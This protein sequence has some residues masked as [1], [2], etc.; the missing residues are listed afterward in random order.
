MDSETYNTLLKLELVNVK[1]VKLKVIETDALRMVKKER[2]LNEYCWTLKPFFLEYVLL[3]YGDLDRVTHLDADLYFYSDPTRLFEN[4]SQS[5]ILISDHDYADIYKES[6]QS[7][8]KT[9]SGIVSFK[10]NKNGIQCL[11]WW[12]DKCLEWCYERVEGNKF[13]DQRYLDEIPSLF[14]GVDYI[15]TPG[16]NIAP[17]NDKKYKISLLNNEILIDKNRLIMYHFSCYKIINKKE[18]LLSFGDNIPIPIIYEPYT[19]ALEK[20]INDIDK[21]NA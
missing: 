4:Q 8:G 12:R 19:Q 10:R 18:F 1:L 13:S 15:T 6:E 9:N 20:A 2:K 3:R 21:L 17:W 16:V 14:E 5:S 7:A 11:R